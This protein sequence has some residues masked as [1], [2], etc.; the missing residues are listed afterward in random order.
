MALN[1]VNELKA[2]V[3][4][5]WQVGTIYQVYPRSLQDSNGDGV[6][7]LRGILSRL[8]YFVAL[9]VDAVWLSPIYPSPMADFGYDVS[10]YTGIAPLFGTM[11]EFDA[12]LAAVH[13]RKLR[14]FL[15]FVPNHTSDQHPWFAQSRSSRTNAKAEWYLWHDP[16]PYPWMKPGE[17]TRPVSEQ[18]PNNWRSHFGG[19][20]WTWCEERQQFYMHSFL[21]AQPDLNWRNPAVKQAMF[22]A[23]R[24]WLAKGVD[25]F[26]MDVLWLLIKD[27]EFRN[28]PANPEYH[29]DSNDFAAT[30]PVYTA[31]QPE[32]HEIVREMRALMDSY[33][34]E[35]HERVLIGE[36]YLPLD[37][38]VRY[39][40]TASESQPAALAHQPGALAEHHAAAEDEAP[41]LNGANLPFNF[42]LIQ[43]PWQAE[44]IAHIV[45]TYEALLPRGAWPN[46]VLGNHDQSRLATRIGAAQ[47]RVAQMLLLTLRGTPTMYYGDE[48]AMTDVAISPAEVRDP[49]ELNEPGKGQG[50]DPERSPMIWTAE[51]NAG[52]TTPEAT[53]WLPILPDFATRCVAVQGK[54]AK[55]MLSLTRA[56]LFMRRRL[57]ALHRGDI[58]DVRAQ[59]GVLSYMRMAKLLDLTTQRMEVH[60]NL[61]AE[62]RTVACA[63]GTVLFTTLMDGAGAPVEGMLTLEANEGALIAVD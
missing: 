51:P 30:L 18:Y 4:P 27:A 16:V 48:L 46:Y 37:E 22:D 5:W 8:E 24:F 9:G 13:Q 17:D 12:L 19:P 40:G 57:P 59:D 50:R 28:N 32:T 29:G 60:L 31:D 62:E 21:A 1:D 61:T 39:Y 34:T 25:G 33:S 58:S 36:I 47:T 26:R 15:D 35:D 23:M 10:D 43:T 55:S 49:A 7:D 42:A 56:L 63:K 41:H 38:L 54:E 11:A 6:G 14:M 53:P 2:L 20:A 45:K 3:K 44:A 52:F